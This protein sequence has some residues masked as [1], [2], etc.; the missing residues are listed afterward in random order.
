MTTQPSRDRKRDA[1]HRESPPR[2]YISTEAH[3]GE[4]AA[5]WRLR[6]G[7]DF[8]RGI[9]GFTHP[10]GIVKSKKTQSETYRDGAGI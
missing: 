5:Q 6:T 7:R 4:T 2:L 10:M 3:D 1:A 8:A 9:I